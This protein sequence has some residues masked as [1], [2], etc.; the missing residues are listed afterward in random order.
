MQKALIHFLGWEDPCRKV[1]YLQYSW[2]PWVVQMI[3]NTPAMWNLQ[4]QS[5]LGCE[6]SPGGRHSKPLVL[7]LRVPMDRK[8][9]VGKVQT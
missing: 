9:L 7:C 4:V 3:K 5:L 1:E 8:G 6:E 2:L